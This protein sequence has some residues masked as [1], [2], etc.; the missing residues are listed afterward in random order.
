M[1][2]RVLVTDVVDEV[3]LTR[4]A[5]LAARRGLVVVPADERAPGPDDAPPV[6]RIKA[7]IALSISF[8]RTM[9]VILFSHLFMMF[10]HYEF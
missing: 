4:L 2:S 3:V 10:L 8:E 6:A 9:R 7:A 1:A 5:A